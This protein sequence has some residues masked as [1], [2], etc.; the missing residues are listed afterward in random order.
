MKVG[1]PPD[2]IGVEHASTKDTN[3][4]E[5]QE[6]LGQLRTGDTLLVHS[7]GRLCRNMA[8]MCAVTTR[9]Y[10]QG[11]T[12]IFLKEQLT[13]SIGTSNSLQR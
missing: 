12:L 7:I 4:P 13:F 2:K 8:D 3:W 11:V 10:R 9:F 6:L 1:F 5:L